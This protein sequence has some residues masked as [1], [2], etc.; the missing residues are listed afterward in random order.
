MDGVV[1]DCTLAGRFDVRLPI[2]KFEQWTRT[3]AHA[4]RTLFS[5]GYYYTR[6]ASAS[7]CMITFYGE[8]GVAESA[9]MLYSQL[10]EH[11]RRCVQLLVDIR[12]AQR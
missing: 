9:A 12:Q 11:V 4:V 8:R 7:G 3:L 10:W 6:A 5:T 2:T 1:A